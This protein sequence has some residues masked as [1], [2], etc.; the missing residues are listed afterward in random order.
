MWTILSSTW[1]LLAAHLVAHPQDIECL[2]RD[3]KPQTDDQCLRAVFDDR[4]ARQLAAGVRGDMLTA[5]DI[6]RFSRP[7]AELGSGRA[8]DKTRSRVERAPE[9]KRPITV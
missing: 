3:L 9:D 2:R 1:P 8:A 6:K 5:S 7:M 4:V